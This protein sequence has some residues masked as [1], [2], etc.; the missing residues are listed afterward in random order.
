MLIGC[1]KEPA[2]QSYDNPVDYIESFGWHIEEK[3]GERMQATKNYLPAKNIGIDLE[4]YEEISIT[5]YLLKEKQKD[6]KKIFADIYQ[7]NEEIIG[8]TGH[9]ENWEPGDFSL[10]DKERL[11]SEEV[12]DSIEANK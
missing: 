8:G 11:L 6:G 9:L 1:S 7:N 12:I 2:V 10:N 5:T 3:V 4:P